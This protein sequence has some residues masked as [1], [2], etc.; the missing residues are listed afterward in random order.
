MTDNILLYADGTMVDLAS[1]TKLALKKEGVTDIDKITISRT[2]SFAIPMTAHNREVFGIL[3]DTNQY[4][5]VARQNIR[6]QL[7][8]DSGVIHGYLI[9]NKVTES[10]IDSTF[11]F[12]ELAELRRLKDSG[13]LADY[14]YFTD[15]V[16]LLQD[17]TD[18]STTSNFGVSRMNNGYQEQPN[19][20][21]LPYVSVG[22]LLQAVENYHGITI[23]SELK[24]SN[25]RLIL[26]SINGESNQITYG[27]ILFQAN[28]THLIG[29]ALT[30]YFNGSQIINVTNPANEQGVP[31]W[32]TPPLSG[33]KCV[34]DCKI[35][36]TANNEI[37]G[38]YRRGRVAYNGVMVVRGVDEYVNT[39]KLIGANELESLIVNKLIGTNGSIN[40]N[41]E[42][43]SG[44]YIF[45][46][47]FSNEQY[48]Y[49]AF[50]NKVA[51]R[52]QRGSDSPNNSVA[53][54]VYMYVADYYGNK[55]VMTYDNVNN[56]Y[57]YGNYYLQDNLPDC[58]AIELLK[59]M[60][61]IK[62]CA[63][64]YDGGKIS[65][66]DY[67]F[68]SI[69][70]AYNHKLHNL[71]NKLLRVKEITRSVVGRSNSRYVY[72]LALD[73]NYPYTGNDVDRLVK[74][75]RIPN[76]TLGTGEDK[77]ETF[78]V[79]ATRYADSGYI[80]VPCCEP[81]DTY[82][83]MPYA[84]K[85]QQKPVFCYGGYAGGGQV[86]NVMPN[87][88]Y[89][90][91]LARIYRLSTAVT[92]DVDMSLNDFINIKS[93]DRYALRGGYYYLCDGT[94]ADGVATLTLQKYK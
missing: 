61:I 41:V 31:V 18:I 26:P 67:D 28:G 2:Q 75:I 81:N 4:C 73:S 72:G 83:N 87:V 11:I 71:D 3:D 10:A 23:D 22:Y 92:C 43:K 7:V 60:A 34:R 49:N 48:R 78:C 38:G 33:V 39:T 21:R 56:R 35:H 63:L 52:V 66:F 40:E 19:G 24:I 84:L 1:D 89:N 44:D 86:Y 57:T 46:L 30:S 80:S 91:N 14:L 55:L 15:Y 74:R 59:L 36:I 37:N 27:S 77:S 58:T 85:E 70:I 32:S 53:L 64:V 47:D 62:G 51:R 88:L 6:A 12:G 65:L 50:K 16:E 17:V 29:S 69:N 9:V 93:L 76:D 42:L 8:Y 20:W 25:A 45:W 82:S 90:A 5:G 54:N 68:D 79:G 94:W 13:K